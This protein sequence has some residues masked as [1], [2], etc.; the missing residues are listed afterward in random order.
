M[1]HE[2]VDDSEAVTSRDYV[3]GNALDEV[4][5]HRKGGG[6]EIR[7]YLH[8]HLNSPA[9]LVE[10]SG[11]SKGTIL[12]R[13]EYDAYGKRSIYDATWNSLTSSRYYLINVAFTGQRIDMLDYDSTAHE[14]ELDMM[15]YKNRWYNTEQGRFISNAPLGYIDGMNMYQYV[16]GDPV[17]LSDTLGYSSLYSPEMTPEEIL[18][19]LLNRYLFKPVRREAYRIKMDKY[20]HWFTGRDEN[21]SKGNCYRFACNDPAGQGGSS[22]E[23]DI[24]P[25][26]ISKPNQQNISCANVIAGAKADGLKEPVNGSCGEGETMVAAAVSPAEDY[27]WYRQDES[28][29][30][31]HKPGSTDVSFED[32]SGHLIFNPEYA[33]RNGRKDRFGNDWDDDQFSSPNYSDICGYLCVSDCLDLDK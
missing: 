12:E 18:K 25:E 24:D 29:L 32:K 2:V 21:G 10:G 31:F 11:A 4:L 19:S 9:A 16:N 7:Y 14:Y 28:G 3:Y 6:T 13:Y 26:G 5:L 27:H 15:Y 20:S 1:L 23:H 22:E 8:D 17:L 30:W 33:N